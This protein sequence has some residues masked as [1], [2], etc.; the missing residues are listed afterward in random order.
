MALA[1]YSQLFWFPSGQLAVNVPARVFNYSVNTFATLW[2]DAAGTVPLANPTSTDAS[3][4][5]TFWAEEARYWLHLD[6]ETFDI[7]LGAAAD[8]P[9]LPKAGGTMTGDLVLAADPNA[10]LEATTKQYTDA[11]DAATLAAAQASAAAG[12]ALKVSKAG[13]TMTGALL[14]NHDGFDVD[15]TRELSVAASTGIV[16]TTG[17][18]T[19]AGPTSVNVPAGVASFT[20]HTALAQNFTEVQY[21]PTVVT[22]D[23]PTDPLTYFMVNDAGA[24]VQNAG[25]PTRA[26]RRQFAVLGRAVVISSV[27]VSV[28]DSPALVT[29]PVSFTQ[30]V[31]SAIGDIRVN[32]IRAAAIASSMTFSLTAGNI[33]NQGANYQFSTDDP[34]VSPFNAV[35]P[36][37][38]RYVTQNAVVP[39]FRT[40]IDPTIYDVGGTV[41]AVPGSSSLT[42]IQRVHCFPTQNVFIQL[43]QN[44]Y[45]NLAEALD[46]LAL[47]ES[48]PYTTHPD[49]TGGGVRTSFIVVE[50]QTTDLASTITARVLRATRFGDPG[51]V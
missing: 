46:A 23:D 48:L 50:R 16:Y 49:L 28:Q 51:G 13:D 27:I 6:S 37:S 24:I 41:T 7:A 18:L 15:V 42:T 26:Q 25:V 19:Q 21:G 35:S 38:F 3:G 47:G 44:L 20:D 33:F 10:P 30:D 32:G 31:V 22:L 39:A 1:Q 14:I 36:T 8:G 29:H 34:N 12:D 2:A 40:T 4:L 45:N 43:G 11:G 17:P 5:L 9:F